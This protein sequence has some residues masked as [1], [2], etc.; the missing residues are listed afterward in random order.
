MKKQAVLKEEVENKGINEKENEIEKITDKQG[1]IKAVL[2]FILGFVT[3]LFPKS[4]IVSPFA[5]AAVASSDGKYAVFT[6]AGAAMGFI[7]SRGIG[8]SVRYIITLCFVLASVAVSKKQFLML[9]KSTVSA[10]L[11]SVFVLLSDVFELIS[12]RVTLSGIILCIA[13][14]LL[15]ACAVY[16]FSR[17]FSVP[18]L[19]TG[20]RKISN[21]DAVCICITAACL[22]CCVGKI[23][24][25]GFYIFHIPACILIMFC[26][27][28]GK[29]SAGSVSGILLGIVLSFGCEIPS[30]FYMYAAGGLVAGVFSFLG[31]YGSAAAFTVSA[32]AAAFLGGAD[33]RVLPL[34]AE[35]VFSSVLFMLIPPKWLSG[36]EEYL[37]GSKIKNS[38]EANMQVAISL[39][40]AAGTVASISDVVTE[41]NDKLEA[42]INPEISK[43]FAR[44]QHNVCTD[45]ENKS[46][47]WN[48]CFDST[49]SDINAIAKMRLNAQNVTGEKLKSLDEICPK[50]QKLAD[51]IDRDYKQ[52]LES[53]DVRMKIEEMRELVSDQFLSMSQMLNDIASFV[54]DEKT[55]D[56]NKSA[57]LRKMLKDNRVKTESAAYRENSFSC[58]VVEI[59]ICEEPEK[60]NSEKIRRLISSH[61]KKK[62]REAEISLE[63][64]R[65]VLIF[66]QGTEYDT[67]I[68]IKQIPCGENKICGDAAH[69]FDTPNGCTAAVISDGMGTGKRAALD[70][71]MTSKIMNRLL[72]SGFTFSSALKLAN[73]ALLIKSGEESMSTVDA[74][75]VN[76]YNAVCTFYKAG[77]CATYIRHGTRILKTELPSLPVG[78]LRNVDFA[79]D[80]CRLGD[81]D[82]I[83]MMSDGVNGAG[84]DEWIKET[85]LCWSTDN[86]QE[87]STHIADLARSKNEKSFPDDITVAAIKIKQK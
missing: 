8:D 43:I 49:V 76:L 55:Y 62:F 48:K 17:S 75:C 78:I 5:F 39:R 50:I 27:F 28:Y 25:N 68:G 6:F 15:C 47:C 3:G 51:E 83:L 81:G 2:Y 70:A 40:Q 30:L 26:A 57:S 35:C 46:V 1:I 77:A 9:E 65:T 22:I 85:L 21:Y 24:I 36:A 67:R 60:I 52:Y 11:S 69:S 33:M 34:L 42:A 74:V 14:A 18:L 61:L 58:A 29:I 19:K 56:E 59:V 87:L 10:L 12:V 80:E 7:L 13:D 82:I 31:Q 41:T 54:A 73:T 45:C 63:D 44:I 79:E 84:D 64:L 53:A 71:E 38:G 66:R 16:F 4:Y 72:S 37:I 20:I 23:N 32:C 86:M